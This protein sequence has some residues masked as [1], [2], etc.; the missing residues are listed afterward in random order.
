[1]SVLMT[2]QEEQQADSRDDGDFFQKG[3]PA[4]LSAVV[5]STWAEPFLLAQRLFGERAEQVLEPVARAVGHTVG[6]LTRPAFAA[7]R[8]PVDHPLEDTLKATRIAENATGI[9]G[10][11]YYLSPKKIVRRIHTCP[12]RHR[13]GA[14]ILCHVGEAAGQELFTEL[15]PGVRHKVHVTMARGHAF[16][17]YSYE[18]D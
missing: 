18:V 9:Y 12:Y 5:R 10:R 4:I 3:L 17:E 8:S 16:C 11:D 14:R 1:M 15:V 13:E 2:S 7:F 6:V